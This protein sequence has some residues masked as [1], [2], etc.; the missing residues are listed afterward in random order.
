MTSGVNAVSLY[1]TCSVAVDSARYLVP[2]GLV[3]AAALAA[4]GRE[5]LGC[6]LKDESVCC[7]SHSAAA[8]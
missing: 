6:G 3:K 7:W 5:K 1:S 2:L 8:S 4:T